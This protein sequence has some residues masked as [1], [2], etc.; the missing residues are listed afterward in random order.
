MTDRSS[1]ATGALGE[2]FVV[3]SGCSGGGKS[4]LLTELSHRGHAVVE[5]PGRR[6][7][8]DELQRGG[9]VLPWLNPIDFARRALAIA[10]TDYSSQ[11]AGI[12]HDGWVFFD[13]GIIDAAAAIAHLTG[14]RVLAT[15]EQTYR[16]HRRVF[17]TPPWPE[18]YS[19]D[20]ERRHDF[21]ASLGEYVRL[22]EV[23][24]LLGYEVYGLPK[25]GI[26][27]RADYLLKV[28]G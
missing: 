17:L 12:C 27:Q 21:E 25:V 5:E 24:P 9:S 16:Y 18:L 11:A 2:R 26:S 7:V 6:I 13:R 1:P 15:I 20:A 3:I 10:K 28:L 22:L 8:Q 14:E 23:Y 19:T 4:A